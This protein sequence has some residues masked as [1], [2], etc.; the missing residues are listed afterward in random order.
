MLYGLR[1]TP[2][3]REQRP[4]CRWRSM[5]HKDALRHFRPHPDFP[6]RCTR[7]PAPVR[8]MPG[9]RVA[10]PLRRPAPNR[11]PHPWRNDH[12]PRPRAVVADQ[13]WRTRRL[14]IAV[15]HLLP[16]V[17]PV[18]VADWAAAVAQ[19]TVLVV[20]DD[21]N[22]RDLIAVKL[23]AAGYRTVLAGDGATALALVHRIHPD[24]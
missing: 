7:P 5:S 16:A 24:M 1:S 15:P 11:Q 8:G 13:H 14:E 9:R 6:G 20:D 12:Y 10:F 22:V 19:P 23:Q 18:P 21:E 3:V 17:L 4:H 2:G